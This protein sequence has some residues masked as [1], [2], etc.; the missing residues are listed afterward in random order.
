MIT[1]RGFRVNSIHFAPK[2]PGQIGRS[3]KIATK[4]QRKSVQRNHQ[5]LLKL[6]V[7]VLLVNTS[8]LAFS[9]L[10]A[11]LLLLDTLPI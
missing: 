6:N 4:T 11:R 2:T 3:Q 9:L 5:L 8:L 10:L 7:I 1:K